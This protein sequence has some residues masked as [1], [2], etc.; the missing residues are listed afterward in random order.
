M[1]K[2]GCAA[3]SS[4][5]TRGAPTT[6]IVTSATPTSA[7]SSP[8]SSRRPSTAAIPTTSSTRATTSISASSASTRTA[9]RSIP[10]ISSSGRPRACTTATWFSCRAIPDAPS[11]SLP[12]RSSPS[13]ATSSTRRPS[14][15]S[16]G[17]RCCS[18]LGRTQ[19]REFPPVPGRVLLDPEFTQGLR[20]APGRAPSRFLLGH[21]AGGRGHPQAPA[22]RPARRR[23]RHR[24]LPA[25]R[26]GPEGHRPRLPALQ[27]AGGGPRLPARLQ[28]RFL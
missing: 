19:R 5:S 10:S 9:R 16:S 14:P 22:L 24:R 11:A 23:S 2:P 13:C 28:L 12:L 25:D 18:T 8:R 3:T 17:G 7:W 1:T 26:G 21:E 15:C 6:S 20:R 4:R 27:L